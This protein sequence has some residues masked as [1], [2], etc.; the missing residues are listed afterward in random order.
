MIELTDE[1]RAAAKAFKEKFGQGVPLAM[2]PPTT[3]TFDLIEKI[4]K[5]IETGNDTL[6]EQYG[7]VIKE[8]D[9]V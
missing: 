4:R 9:L 2:I 8:G 5:C 7:V 3:N 6:L 1:Y